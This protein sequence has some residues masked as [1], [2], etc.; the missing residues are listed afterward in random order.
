L[1]SLVLKRLSKSFD[2][3]PVVADANI[4]IRSGEFFSILGP[5]GCGKTTLLR[6]IAGFESPTSGN[7]ILDGHD[8]TSL[9]PRLRKIGMV[10]QNYALFPHMTVF[11]NVAF[12]LESQNVPRDQ[13]RKRVEKML[14]SVGLGEKTDRPVPQ[15]SGG[16]QQ[17]VAVA[18]ALVVEPKVLLFDEPLSNLDVALRL[19]T[20][21]EIRTLQ[22]RTGITTIY[23][24]HDQSEA[25]SL[26]DRIAVMRGGQIEQIGAPHE[27][28]ESPKSI[29]VGEFL[30]GANVLQGEIISDGTRFR[31]GAFEVDVPTT[32]DLPDGTVT[33]LIKPEAILLSPDESYDDLVGLIEHKEYLG[34]TTNL[35]IRIDGSRVHA[36]ALS[37][38]QTRGLFVGA[39]VRISIDWMKCTFLPTGR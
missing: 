18:R 5:S 35:T 14:D 10:F 23:V 8:V 38:E 20:R 36:S 1:S 12:G 37:S 31:V 24:T 39:K 15:L 34:F 27:V 28:Y 22:R 26:S 9:P 13:I 25:M 3:T 19:K 29:F 32:F 4:E 2:A 11:Q 7:I 33:L 16:E 6:M 30:G 21:E 17:R